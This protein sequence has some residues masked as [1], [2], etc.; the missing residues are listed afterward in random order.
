MDKRRS[1]SQLLSELQKNPPNIRNI[2]ILAHVDHGKTTLADSLV[3]SNG[4]ISERLAGKLRYMDFR[5]DEQERGITMK[6]SSISLHHNYHDRDYLI[7]LI[8]SPGHVDFASEVS[9][10]VRLCDGALIVVDVVEGV[11][12]QTRSALSM[13][14][15]EGLKPIL[16]LN[17]IDRLINE[18]KLTPL[19]AYVHL[20]QVLEQVNA[21]MGELF[22]SDIMEREDKLINTNDENNVDN[23]NGGGL[24][25]RPVAD[26]Q[27]ALENTDDSQLYFSPSQGNVL[28][29]SS[30]DGW[31]FSISDFALIYANKIGCSYKILMKTL[32]GDYWLNT[33]EKKIMKNAQLKAKKPLFVSLILENIWKLNDIILSR[34]DDSILLHC[35]KKM[36]ILVTKRDFKLTDVKAKLQAIFSEWLP[37]A[38]VALDMVC[39]KVPSPNNLTSDKIERLMSG[40]YE[41]SNLPDDTKKLKN[42]FLSCNSSDDS[43]IIVFVSKMFS[44]ERKSLPEFKAKP[45]TQEELIQRR[46]LARQRHAAKIEF[47]K[48]NPGQQMVYNTTD[49]TAVEMNNPV[50]NNDET[51]DDNDSVLIAFARIY[52]GTI[53]EGSEVYVLGPKHKP[54]DIIKKIN[55]G[56]DIT[57]PNSIKELKNGCY[58]TKTTIKKLYLL[59]GRELRSIDCVPAGNVFGIGGLENNILKTG[60]I[61]TD[62]YCPSFS[63]LTSLTVPILRVALEPVN[64]CDLQKLINGLKLL[65]QADSCALMHIQETGEIVL[66]TAGEVHLQRCLEDLKLHYAKI[67][68]IVSEPIVPFRETIV[69]PPKIDMVNELITDNDNKK[70]D[71][72]KLEFWTSNRQCYFVIDAKPL[73][74][75][76]IKLIEKNCDLIKE[77]DHYWEKFGKND[78]FDLT[79]LNKLSLNDQSMSVKKQ[80]AIDVFKSELSSAFIE[81]GWDDVI[82][83]IW[84]FGPRKCGPNILLNETDYVRKPFWKFNSNRSNDIRASYDISIINGFQVATVAGPLCEEPM[85][86][87][88]FVVN[89]LEIHERDS[90]R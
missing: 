67:D 44:I 55:S 78:N 34:Q 6:S 31:G 32:W 61:S 54:N 25:E 11:C 12:P 48:Q 76:V 18:L 65:N 39:Q 5:P 62:I 1:D 70:T 84:S 59:M 58:I 13:A 69:A 88:C 26:W 90:Q 77:L 3:A 52:S 17:K 20:V 79:D 9:T 63:E 66:N 23:T 71:D 24:M 56:E 28:F 85:T 73:P 49:N 33:K 30:V 35:L 45:L 47:E 87:V 40:N 14:Y 2:C 81:A 29:A 4:I 42:A 19:D 68:I 64:S 89:K 57:P 43:P 46:E 86:G 16:V 10:A 41:F 21:V 60:T 51:V 7:N 8:D 82:D 72:S 27:S 74:D 37:L 36:D 22:T 75:S 83:K 38:K 50:D 53:K 80:K 15:I